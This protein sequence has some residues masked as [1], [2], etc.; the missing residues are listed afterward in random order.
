MDFYQT[1]HRRSTI[2]KF[3]AD[4]VPEGSVLRILDAGMRAPSP[5]H[6]QPWEF[7]WIKDPKL[8]NKL[9]GLKFQS[10]LRMAR[11]LYPELPEDSI[12]KLANLQ[13]VA[14]ETAAVLIAVCYRDLDNPAEIGTQRISLSHAAAWQCIENMWLAATA[15]GIGFSPTFYADDVYSN[16]R[17][18]LCLP[19]GVELAAIVRMGFKDQKEKRKPL[20]RL[21]EKLHFDKF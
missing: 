13:K 19:E 3:R 9:A 1:I 17:K 8:R 2:R 5:E 21:E 11:I 4:A 7:I 6:R 12:L 16:A 18:L 10:R 20:K 15:E 14:L